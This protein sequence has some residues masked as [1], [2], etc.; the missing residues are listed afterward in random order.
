MNRQQKRLMKMKPEYKKETISFLP[1]QSIIF[2]EERK[3]LEGVYCRSAEGY[4]HLFKVGMVLS[5]GNVI[6]QIIWTN[7]TPYFILS[8]PRGRELGFF[9]VDIT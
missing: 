7:N 1:I 6:T 4:D 2:G 9:I 3:I 5:N 8:T